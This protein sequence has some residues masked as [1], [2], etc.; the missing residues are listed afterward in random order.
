MPKIIH[1]KPHNVTILTKG[2]VI[3]ECSVLS[4]PM[5][6]IIWKKNNKKI[7]ENKK[8]KI[9][10][11]SNLSYLRI[12]DASQSPN[13][14]D[15]SC[16]AENQIG[17]AESHSFLQILAE[18]DKIQYKFPEITISNPKS[19]EPDTPFRID[20]ILSDDNSAVNLEWYQSNKLINF[21]NNKLTSNTTNLNDGSIRHSL[22]VKGISLQTASDSQEIEYA[23]MTYNSQITNLAETSILLRSK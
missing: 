13:S 10:H 9:I 4:Y 14:L 12:T 11:S 8:F 2:N 21:D 3:F 15:I 5:A 23:C 6:Q 1:L 22:Y 20:C 18:K 19:V 17:T 7:N 16:H